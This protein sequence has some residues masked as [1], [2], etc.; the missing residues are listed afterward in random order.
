MKQYKDCLPN[1]TINKIKNILYN[2]DL[3]TYESR[4]FLNKSKFYSLRVELVDFPI[5]AN[6]KGITRMYAMASAYAE[7]IEGIQ[8]GI[9]M[10][11]KFGLKS[12]EYINIYPDFI[13][14][15]ASDFIKNK[16][17]PNNLYF[18]DTS[19]IKKQMEISTLFSDCLPY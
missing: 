7:L 8:N 17:L 3:S 19:T 14:F 2:A 10:P 11:N 1:I 6:G 9:I 16:F 15:D 5:G 4:W 12:R 18:A 13:K